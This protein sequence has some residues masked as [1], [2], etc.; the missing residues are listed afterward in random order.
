MTDHQDDS[1]I[2]HKDANVSSPSISDGIQQSSEADKRKE[3]PTAGVMDAD[4]ITKFET[5]R[6][7]K[8]APSIKEGPP[9]SR[10]RLAPRGGSYH[11]MHDKHKSRKHKTRKHKSR[12]HKSRKHKSRK[13]KSRKHKKY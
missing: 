10:R 7:H 4:E 3:A 2:I 9:S 12:K 11:H 5:H 13:H 8:S 1:S 6:G